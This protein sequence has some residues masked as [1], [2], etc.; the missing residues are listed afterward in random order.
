MIVH[1]DPLS[2]LNRGTSPSRRST[3]VSGL[4][5][6]RA[7]QDGPYRYGHVFADAAKRRLVPIDEAIAQARA[8][9]RAAEA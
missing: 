6:T 7:A 3:V 5:Q 8:L 9:A 4:E 1:L 2:H